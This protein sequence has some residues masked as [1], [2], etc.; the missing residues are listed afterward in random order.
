MV[1]TGHWVEDGWKMRSAILDF[2]RFPTPHT[3]E[4]TCHFVEEAVSNWNLGAAIQSI[5]RN[6]ATDMI[7]GARKLWTV[8][9]TQHPTSHPTIDIFH[10]RCISHVLNITVKE[11]TEDRERSVRK[12]RVVVNSLRALLKRKDAFCALEKSSTWSSPYLQLTV[13]PGGNLRSTC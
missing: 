11:Y 1:V 10:V 5:S 3:G 7:S 8:L 6:N 9:R 13:R 4:A 12:L 2:R